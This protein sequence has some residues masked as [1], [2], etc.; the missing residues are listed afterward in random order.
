MSRTVADRCLALAGIFQAV[1]AVHAVARSGTAPTERIRPLLDSLFVVDAGSTAEVYGGVTGLESG[2]RAVA[3]RLSGSTGREGLAVT[4][5]VITLIHLAGK[6][7]RR[8]DLLEALREGIEAARGQLAYFGDVTHDT[9]LAALAALYQ[10][11]VSTLSPRVMVQGD[12]AILARPEHQNLI[13]ALLLAGIRS[14]IL[15]QQSGGRRWQLLL[16]RRAFQE[17]ADSL[18][19]TVT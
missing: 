11:T 10:K 13:R 18:L 8:P 1:E 6:L 4:R 5:H 15:W 3:A 9:V 16:R 14:A 12:P 17:A 19:A 2:L 7:Q